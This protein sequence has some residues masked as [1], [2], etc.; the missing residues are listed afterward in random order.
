MICL[1]RSVENPEIPIDTDLRVY[2]A[3]RGFSAQK[4]SVL[5]NAIDASGVS[6][7]PTAHV[8]YW[9]KGASAVVRPLELRRQTIQSRSIQKSMV[10]KASAVYHHISTTSNDR[11]V[12]ERFCGA[13]IK[14]IRSGSQESSLDAHSRIIEESI[15]AAVLKRLQQE[16]QRREEAIQD[17]IIATETRHLQELQMQEDEDQSS[18]VTVSTVKQVNEHSPVLPELD[19]D[20]SSLCD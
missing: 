7:V 19:L 20:S 1:Y 11:V 5:H 13:A 6:P 3:G 15:H 9:R 4:S 17:Q 8:K 14:E 10:A 12:G 2:P 18:L 16:Q